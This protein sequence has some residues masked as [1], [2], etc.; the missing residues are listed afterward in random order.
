MAEPQ[1]KR[2]RTAKETRENM[3]PFSADSGAVKK[4]Y[5]MVKHG[6][7]MVAPNIDCRVDYNAHLVTNLLFASFHGFE[8]KQDQ[9]YQ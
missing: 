4:F 7:A 9:R 2:L 3:D 1:L 6:M 5:L 8:P